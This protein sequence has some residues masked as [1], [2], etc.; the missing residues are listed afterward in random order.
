MFVACLSAFSLPHS[1]EQT[2]IRRY[3]GRTSNGASSLRRLSARPLS[4]VSCPSSPL[5]R[6]LRCCAVAPRPARDTSHTVSRARWSWRFVVARQGRSCRCCACLAQVSS[7]PVEGWVALELVQT[8]LLSSMQF[9]MKEV[10]ALLFC[11]VDAVAKLLLCRRRVRVAAF[12][13]ATYVCLSVGALSNRIRS[14]QTS[15]SSRVLSRCCTPS[16]GRNRGRVPLTT[17]CL[18]ICRR[19]VTALRALIETLALALLRGRDRHLQDLRLS[20]LAVRPGG[21]HCHVDEAAVDGRC[22]RAATFPQLL[23]RWETRL[24]LL[25]WDQVRAHTFIFCVC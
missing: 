7:A 11:F 9:S 16:C 20:E 10:G 19:A 5:C 24:G 15:C 22:S 2:T 6:S 12:M 23:T 18:P 8:G 1:H 25:F 3:A 14:P 21:E 13:Y 4:L 17:T